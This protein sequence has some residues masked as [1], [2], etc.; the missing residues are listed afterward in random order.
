M[1]KS[2]VLSTMALA[3][4]SVFT[5]APTAFADSANAAAIAGQQHD[6]QVEATKTQF[7]KI[8]EE[9]S[10]ER[11]QALMPSTT[12]SDKV[13]LD[14]ELQ[15]QTAQLQALGVTPISAAQAQAI[16]TASTSS[17]MTPQVVTPP[18]TSDVNWYSYNLTF[19]DGGTGKTYDV[20]ELY[21]QGL[22]SNSNLGTAADAAYFTTNAAFDPSVLQQ[23][24]ISL[25]WIYGSKLIGTVVEKIPYAN[26]LPWELLIPQPPSGVLVNSQFMTYRG[27]ETVCFAYVKPDGMSDSYQSLS[28]ISN[29]VSVSSDYHAAGFDGHGGSYVNNSAPVENNAMYSQYYADTT[30]EVTAYENYPYAQ[31]R[32]WLPSYSFE[33]YDHSSSVSVSLIEPSFPAQIS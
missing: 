12:A 24:G 20:Q 13:A 28:F 31:S 32:S 22:N 4:V 9:M 1:K 10:L 17:T 14:T 30:M 7:R 18:S 25:L 33:N 3:A 23:E 15:N 27:L 2:L 29:M 26:L 8:L 21:A 11:A 5:L 19:Y 6:Q 16:Q